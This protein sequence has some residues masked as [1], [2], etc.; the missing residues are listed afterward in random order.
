MGWRMKNII[1]AKSQIEFYEDEDEDEDEDVDDND[2]LSMYT[3]S[4][5]IEVEDI[6]GI[7]RENVLALLDLQLILNKA[8]ENYINFKVK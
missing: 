5:M 2:N 4:L 6:E 3:Y 7:T 1:Y 8:A